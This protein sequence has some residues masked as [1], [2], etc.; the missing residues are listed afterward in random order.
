MLYY[1]GDITGEL[2]PDHEIIKR[3][4]G[5]KYEPTYI[6]YIFSILEGLENE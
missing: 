6:T 5:S 4:G 3:F 2:H 1:S